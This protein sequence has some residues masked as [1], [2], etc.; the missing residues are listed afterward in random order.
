M[1]RLFLCVAYICWC[2][3]ICSWVLCIGVD[4][5]PDINSTWLGGA[6]G[7]D[8]DCICDRID[9]THHPENMVSDIS[10][11]KDKYMYRSLEIPLW[12]LNANQVTFIIKLRYIIE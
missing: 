12:V 8:D 2:I 5:Y 11:L 10:S 9:M 4:K 6:C 1:N 7:W 3:S